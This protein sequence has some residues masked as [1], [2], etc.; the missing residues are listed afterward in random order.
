MLEQSETC[1][2]RPHRLARPLRYLYYRIYAWNL[3][4][5][6]EG[7]LPQFNAL[8]GTSFLMLMNLL[9]IPFI[10]DFLKIATMS[11]VAFRS[12]VI[13]LMPVTFLA[14]YLLLFRR[15]RYRRIFKEFANEAEDSRRRGTIAVL[16]YVAISVVTLFGV[17]MA[18]AIGRS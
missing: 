10:L 9:S 17:A 11:S 12:L 15:G 18:G 6:G 3:H 8:L 14:H 5:Q 7:D 13:A 16:A 1:V 4:R 2:E